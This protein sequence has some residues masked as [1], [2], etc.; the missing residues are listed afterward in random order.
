MAIGETVTSTEIVRL[1]TCHFAGTGIS[2]LTKPRLQHMAS[3]YESPDIYMFFL[4]EILAYKHCGM[5][6]AARQRFHHRPEQVVK[7]HM[8]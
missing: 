1:D 6:M 3:Q 8:E 7:W 2:N 5:V 4:D